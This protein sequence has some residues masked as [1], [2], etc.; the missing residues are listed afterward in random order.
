MRVD[1]HQH[2]HAIPA[3]FD[4]LSQAMAELGVTVT[5]LRCPIE[6]SGT[7]PCCRQQ[8]ASRQPGKGRAHHVAVAQESRQDARRLRGPAILRRG[9]LGRHGHGRLAAL[10]RVREPGCRPRQERPGAVSP[11]QRA[12]RAMPPTRK[13]PPS[14]P[15][16]HP[17]PATAKPNAY[18]IWPKP[19]DSCH[20]EPAGCTPAAVPQ[21]AKRRP[22][23]IPRR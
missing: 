1:S 12:D 5:H 16:A 20:A 8:H 18:A 21:P 11:G 10:G 2:T 17:R 7:A 6:P 14:P 9:A 19:I 15:P 13:T 23:P 22:N 3:V 4:A